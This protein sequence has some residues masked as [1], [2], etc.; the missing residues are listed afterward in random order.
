MKNE[1]VMDVEDGEMKGYQRIVMRL[2]KR[3][4]ELIPESW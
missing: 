3:S 2:T 1:G 4:K